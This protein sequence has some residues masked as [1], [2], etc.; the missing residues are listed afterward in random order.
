MHSAPIPLPGQTGSLQLKTEDVITYC[1]VRAIGWWS[2]SGM[3]I[4]TGN[5][6]ARRE[7]RSSVTFSAINIVMIMSHGNETKAAR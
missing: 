4:S 3:L 6:S 7:I 1:T 5:S 2:N